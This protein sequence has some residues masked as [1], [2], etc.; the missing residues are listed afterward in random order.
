M[1]KK[2]SRRIKFYSSFIRATCFFIDDLFFSALERRRCFYVEARR[3]Q[4][5]IARKYSRKRTPF[6]VTAISYLYVFR[7]WR[8]SIRQRNTVRSGTRVFIRDIFLLITFAHRKM[9]FLSFPSLLPSHPSLSLCLSFLSLVHH[10]SL[11]L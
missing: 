1:K 4:C 9:T 11:S 5:K 8:C 7:S 3:I 10:S 2:T 6:F